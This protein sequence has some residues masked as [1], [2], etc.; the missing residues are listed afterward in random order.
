MPKV[1]CGT[2]MTV[3]TRGIKREALMDAIN[4]VKASRGLR[5]DWFVV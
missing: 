4:W 3:S 1:A 5:V 2:M